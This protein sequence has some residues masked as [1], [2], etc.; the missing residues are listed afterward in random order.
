MSAETRPGDEGFTRRPEGRLRKTD[1]RVE[2]GGAL[3]E[4]NAQLGCC[5]AAA[6]GAPQIASVLS[7]VQRDLFA[8]GAL[9]GGTEPALDE[10]AVARLEREVAAA[11]GQ[12]PALTHFI[13][14]GGCELACRLHVA[15][16]VCR[17]AERALVAVADAGHPVPP[18]A[19]RYANRL[20]GL[21]FTLARLANRLAGVQESAPGDPHQ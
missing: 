2:A 16:T 15:R 6:G 10:Q 14:P 19:L 4:L 11:Q 18:A 5:A 3:D 8:L 13:V 21:L 20:G 7:V 12:L 1:P 17:R 9:L